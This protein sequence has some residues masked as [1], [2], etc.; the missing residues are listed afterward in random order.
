MYVRQYTRYR[1][2]DKCLPS[3]VESTYLKED[4][5]ACST[6]VTVTLSYMFSTTRGRYSGLHFPVS[7]KLRLLC[8][9][10]ESSGVSN[11]KGEAQLLVLNRK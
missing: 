4:S 10:S 3:I 5:C 6:R 7:A 9:F 2:L 11:D 8:F 1:D